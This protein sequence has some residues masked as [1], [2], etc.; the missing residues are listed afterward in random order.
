M[1]LDEYR[2]IPM[3]PDGSLWI[4]RDPF[5]FFLFLIHFLSSV[6]DTQKLFFLAGSL[7]LLAR[8]PILL[9][10]LCMAAR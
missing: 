9:A 4:L 10:V 1:D 7:E 6:I 8:R 5:G 2:W 3:D